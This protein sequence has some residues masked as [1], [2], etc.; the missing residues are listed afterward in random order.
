MEEGGGEA[1]R[2]LGN[3]WHMAVLPPL[4]NFAS[5]NLLLV[6]LQRYFLLLPL[7]QLPC[8]LWWNLSITEQHF[9]VRM[10]RATVRSVSDVTCLVI[11]WRLTCFF[12]QVSLKFSPG[13]LQCSIVAGM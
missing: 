9:A 13:P 2:S 8:L 1:R 7:P 6:F 5:I 4:L 11:W 12:W 3:D 10:L